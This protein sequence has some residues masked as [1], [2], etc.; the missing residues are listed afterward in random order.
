MKRQEFHDPNFEQKKMCVIFPMFRF[1]FCPLIIQ[2]NSCSTG[3]F[4]FA[5]IPTF[6]SRE[7][8]IGILKWSNLWVPIAHANMSVVSSSICFTN[9]IFVCFV[10]IFAGVA[11]LHVCLSVIFFLVL[12][13]LNICKCA[14]WHRLWRVHQA[15][16]R[17]VADFR[18]N[19]M[20]KL[21]CILFSFE[22]ERHKKRDSKKRNPHTFR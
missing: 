5:F 15:F 22:I 20:Q 7:K 11:S 9:R 6:R 19:A 21:H 10:C 18:G 4:S 3:Y 17:G 14:Y 16:E 12:I 13:R 1:V 2:H 8:K